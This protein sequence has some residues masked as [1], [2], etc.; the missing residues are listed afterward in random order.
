MDKYAVFGNPIAHSKSP[1]IHKMFAEQTGQSLDYSA[2]LSPL[3]GFADTIRA[4]ISSG[5]KGANVTVPFK[6]QAYKLADQLSE[7]AEQ[8][9]AVNTLIYKEGKLYGDNTDGIGLVKDLLFHDV[10]LQG[11][12][13]LIIGAGGATRGVVLPILKQTPAS[14]H[15]ANRTAEKALNLATHFASFASVTGSG[16]DDIPHTTFDLIINASSS[17]LSGDAPNIDA[18]YIANKPVC[19]DMVYGKEDTAF[20]LWCQQQGTSVTL[21]GLGMLVEQAAQS[22]YLWRG[23]MPDTQ[24]VRQALRNMLAQS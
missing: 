22:F 6:E 10:V 23:V 16:L 18:A 21:D 19:Y 13:I 5:G 8:A 4:F 11:K 9:G 14:L 15:I 12:K 17:S 3:D 20:N 2:I 24:P 1:F 7:A